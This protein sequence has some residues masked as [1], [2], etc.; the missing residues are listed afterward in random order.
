MKETLCRF[1]RSTFSESAKLFLNVYTNGLGT[2]FEIAAC[3]SA[4]CSQP[5][6]RP[7]ASKATLYSPGQASMPD[8]RKIYGL[9][10]AQ[11]SGSFP[12]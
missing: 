10:N 11:F 9:S 5:I 8:E 4:L 3:G 2:N 1:G 7:M 12:K 6:Q